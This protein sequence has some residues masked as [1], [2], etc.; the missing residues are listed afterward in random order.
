MN[1][2]NNE[3]GLEYDFPMHISFITS[4]DFWGNITLAEELVKKECKLIKEFFTE[5]ER[6]KL[7]FISYQKIDGDSPNE[8]IYGTML[9][10]CNHPRVMDFILDKLDVV[11]DSHFI[12]NP[13]MCDGR[14]MVTQRAVFFVTPLEEYIMPQDDE[15]IIDG[16]KYSYYERVEK[17]LNWIN[18]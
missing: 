6:D 3:Y 1:S 11:I 10:T 16:Y 12:K 2:V 9:G 15:Y 8:C 5:E 14:D 7:K 18:E 4:E 13:R 17:V